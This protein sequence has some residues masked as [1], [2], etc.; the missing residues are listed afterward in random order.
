MGAGGDGEHPQAAGVV[1]RGAGEQAIAGADEE[2]AD[3]ECAQ[4]GPPQRLATAD[5]VKLGHYGRIEPVCYPSYFRDGDDHWLWYSD[6]K[7]FVLGKK[8]NAYLE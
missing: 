8:L 3:V 1:C 4:F 2:V 6:R 7:H 5:G